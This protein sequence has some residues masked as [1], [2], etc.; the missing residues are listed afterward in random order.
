MT[1]LAF[2]IGMGG[3]AKKNF[4]DKKFQWQIKGKSE[5]YFLT[6]TEI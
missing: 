3:R 4:Q 6:P 5:L 1:I 2:H